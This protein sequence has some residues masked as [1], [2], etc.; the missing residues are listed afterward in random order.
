[1]NFG[2]GFLCV[3][4][5]RLGSN[6]IAFDGIEATGRDEMRG[7]RI[8]G[9]DVETF[10]HCADREVIVRFKANARCWTIRGPFMSVDVVE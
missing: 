2:A 3:A 9:I 8:E 10:L 5:D 4:R 1:M 6:A 7:G